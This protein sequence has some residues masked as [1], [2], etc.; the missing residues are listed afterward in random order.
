MLDVVPGLERLVG[1]QPPAPALGGAEFQQRFRLV[2]RRLFRAL[3]SPRHPLVIFLDDLQW[4]DSASL[5]LIEML[6]SDPD[7]TGL[8]MIGAYRDNEVQ[9]G[10]PLQALLE[11]WRATRR[12]AGASR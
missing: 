11:S 2:F 8:L 10:H 12:P 9:A 5:A 3:A 1:A 7:L 6:M 4:A